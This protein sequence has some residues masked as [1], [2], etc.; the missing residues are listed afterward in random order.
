MNREKTVLTEAAKKKKGAKDYSLFAQIFA[1][2]WVV[3][4]TLCKG[5]GVV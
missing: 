4:L 3:V 1:S 2:V 5:F